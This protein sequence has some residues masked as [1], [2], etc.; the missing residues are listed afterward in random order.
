MRT[1]ILLLAC[2]GSLPACREVK[3]PSRPEAVEANAALVGKRQ[4]ASAAKGSSTAEPFSY[5]AYDGLLKAYVDDRG[6]VD[7]EGLKANRAAFDAFITDLGA[8]EREQYLGWTESSKLA[9]WL[10]AYNAVT[11]KYIVDAYPIEK[12]SLFSGLRYPANSIRQIRGVWDKLTTE[13]LGEERTLDEMEH[14]IMRVEFD[15]PRIHLAVVCASIG[16]SPLRGGAFT[17]EGLDEQLDGQARDFLADPKKFRIDRDR[18][19]VYF[20]PIF[21]WYGKDFV[22]R[23]GTS[24]AFAGHGKVERA[25]LNFFS[26]YLSEEDARYLAE[27]KY[28]VDY[29]DYDWSLNEQ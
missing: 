13:V 14:E 4:E 16:C 25:V 21:D 8:V 28:A 12:G 1:C 6:R 5:E 7:Y 17:A 23:F 19:R 3:A 9:F 29:L 20:S 18:A 11:L 2:A 27:E 26:R 24:D 15:E 22:P 10:N